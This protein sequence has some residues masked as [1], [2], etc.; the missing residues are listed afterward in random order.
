MFVE[1]VLPGTD[2]DRPNIRRYPKNGTLANAT[3]K[4]KRRLIKKLL[5]ILTGIRRKAILYSTDTFYNGQ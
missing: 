4:V 5:A 1:S 3:P 2:I